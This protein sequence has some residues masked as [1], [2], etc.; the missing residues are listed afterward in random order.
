MKEQWEIHY[1]RFFNFPGLPSTCL[2]LK[3]LPSRKLRSIG[4]WVSSP[5]LASLQLITNPN[6]H[7][8]VLVVSFQGKIHEEH[9]ASKL[10]FTWPQVSCLAEC[11]VRGSKVVFAS[12]KDREGQESLKDAR[13]V[14][15]PSSNRGL[16]TS[17]TSESV[18]LNGFTSRPAVELCHVNPIGNHEP[19]Q[20]PP[21]NDK[22]LK[23]PCPKE[24]IFS[25]NPGAKDANFPS[26]FTALLSDSCIETELGTVNLMVEMNQ[27]HEWVKITRM[28][29]TSFVLLK[30][31]MLQNYQKHQ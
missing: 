28:N 7:G 8:T 14:W 10:H 9:Y 24:S 26:S 29:K 2:S 18:D 19:L 23:C 6:A 22:G 1:S 3:P 11:P 17:L 16:A 13:N 20:Q 5:S 21:S 15:L 27:L 4:N 30:V 12:Y 31:R 25:P